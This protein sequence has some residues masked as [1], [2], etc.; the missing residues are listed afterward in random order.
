MKKLSQKFSLASKVLAKIQSN[1]IKM[2]PKI[3]FILKTAS[4]ILGACIAGLFVLYL[5]SFIVFSLQTSGIWYLPGFGPRGLKTVLF[6][7]PWILFI[8]SAVLIIILEILIKRFS[9]AYCRPIL[10]SIAGIIIFIIFGSLIIHKTHFHANL[11]HR[12]QEGRLPLV[13]QFYRGFNPMKH[14]NVH[15]GTITEIIDNGL[16]MQTFED[17]SLTVTINS[18]TRLPVDKNF[19]AGDLIIVFGE[20][21]D[22]RVQAFGIRLIDDPP[23]LFPPPRRRPGMRS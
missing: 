10:Y 4:V 23:F 11:F 17:T 8:I 21:D 20:R 6:L 1:K 15:Q 2:R 18:N 9:F 16:I 5:T 22:S 12:A 19:K 14:R 7:L 13:G 3:H